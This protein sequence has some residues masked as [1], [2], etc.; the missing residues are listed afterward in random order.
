MEQHNSNNNKATKAKAL[1]AG[2]LDNTIMPWIAWT[3]KSKDV[4]FETT[5]KGGGVGDGEEKVAAE[6]GARV[7]GQNSHYDM[8]FEYDGISTKF[9][10]KK[11]DANDDFNTGKDGRDALRPLKLLHTKL[12]SNIT[13]LSES[14]HFTQAELISLSDLK[15][16]SPDELAVGTLNKMVKVCNMLH[17]KQK[18]L[19]CNLP[20]IPLTTPNKTINMQIDD[21]YI[22]CK[23]YGI[24]FPEEYKEYIETIE[25]LGLLK[26]QYICEPNELMCHLN[27][28][29][30]KLFCKIKLIIVDKNKGYMIL[31]DTTHIKFLRITRGNPRFQVLFF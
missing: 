12:L 11:L 24:P 29:V 16:V 6:V 17:I 2:I 21:Y 25:I 19:R 8:E 14:T 10:V 27:D 15:E 9:D 20:T 30:E 3:E 28:L 13:E 22:L 7:M 4:L 26:N 18:K 5:Q 31:K 23:N 1:K